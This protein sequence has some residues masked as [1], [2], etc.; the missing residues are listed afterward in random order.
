MLSLTSQ[1]PS[2]IAA[3]RLLVQ[4][5]CHLL[6]DHG[7]LNIAQHLLGFRKAEPDL[8]RFQGVTL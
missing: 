2:A 6:L 4:V 5:F 3:A 1:G 7:A 8:P